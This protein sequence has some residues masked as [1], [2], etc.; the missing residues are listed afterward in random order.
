MSNTTL[1]MDNIGK[2]IKKY[3]EQSSISQKKL[4]TTLG[5]TDKAISSYESGR[6]VPSIEVLFRIAKQLNR[7]L[8]LFIEDPTSMSAERKL[9]DVEAKLNEIQSLIKELKKEMKN[10]K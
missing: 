5:I 10:S 4:A 2:L 7:P 8:S 3:R 9:Y 6:T 1:P